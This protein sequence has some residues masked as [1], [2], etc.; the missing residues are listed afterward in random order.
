MLV[1]VLDSAIRLPVQAHPDPVF[2]RRYLSSEYGKTEAWLILATREN[3]KIYFGFRREISRDEFQDAINKSE[4]EQDAMEALLHPVPVQA[5]DVFLVPAHT[6][7]AIGAE[8]LILEVQ[9]PTD[10]T[11]QPEAWCGEYHLSEF[12]KYLGLDPLIALSCFDLSMTGERALSV[13]KKTPRTTLHTD[14]VYSEAL[15]DSSDTPCFALNR[16]RLRGGSLQGFKA[17]SVLLVIQGLGL[18]K[19]GTFVKTIK[20]GDYFLLPAAAGASTISTD[21]ELEIIECLP[22]A[23]I[24]G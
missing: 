18:L 19:T 17:P 7:H 10:F 1:K 24:K 12:E 9:E 21:G 23:D 3:A 6:V 16:H 13:G 14:S 11:I 5:G 15:I 22:P 4:T 20:K 8:C 2:S